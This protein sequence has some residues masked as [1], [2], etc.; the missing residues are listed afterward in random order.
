MK[1]FSFWVV[2]LLLSG[3][4]LY[5]ATLGK[6]WVMG[7][8]GPLPFVWIFYWT[9]C[10]DTDKKDPW[11]KTTHIPRW[12][13]QKAKLISKEFSEKPSMETEKIVFLSSRLCYWKLV[14]DFKDGQQLVV[15]RKIKKMSQKHP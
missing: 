7:I 14:F 3:L 10:L 4:L 2:F 12:L 8:T 15:Y 1:R 13:K 11:E 5:S 9:F 6:E